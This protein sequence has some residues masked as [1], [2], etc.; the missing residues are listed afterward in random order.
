MG[1]VCRVEGN[2][3]GN[4]ITNS[5]I[6]KIY[7]KKNK[8]LKHIQSRGGGRS[9]YLLI[10]YHPS[11]YYHTKRTVINMIGSNNKKREGR[12]KS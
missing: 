10:Y 8:T 7:L 5:I 3:G 9:I 1:G 12:R 4:W 2:K 6:N 11:F